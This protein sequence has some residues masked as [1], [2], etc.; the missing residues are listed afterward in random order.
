MIREKRA[1]VIDPAKAVSMGLTT[2]SYE[3]LLQLADY[4][5]IIPKELAEG[6]R[7]PPAPLLWRWRWRWRP[8][9]RQLPTDK[10]VPKPANL[11]RSQSLYV[12]THR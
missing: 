12:D 8:S 2:A 5:P 1:F 7:G 6:A 3:Q 9:R 10:P 4:R 11:L